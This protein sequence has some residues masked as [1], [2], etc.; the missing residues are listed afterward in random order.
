MTTRWRGFYAAT[1]R[2]SS[3]LAA[4]EVVKSSELEDPDRKRRFQTKMA[5]TIKIIIPILPRI[6]P[7]ITLS[8][9]KN[10][11]LFFFHFDA[12]FRTFVQYLPTKQILGLHIIL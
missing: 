2:L 9:T 11:H 1:S 3:S 10:R 12:V 4:S 6:T 8:L 5:A 7:P